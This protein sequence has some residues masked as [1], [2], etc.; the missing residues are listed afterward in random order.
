MKIKFKK[1]FQLSIYLLVFLW[2]LQVYAVNTLEMTPDIGNISKKTT[3]DSK[4]KLLFSK[5]DKTTIIDFSL[6]T[7][8]PPSL[9]YSNYTNIQ[10]NYGVVLDKYFGV[11]KQNLLLP[12][13]SMNE[14][15]PAGVVITF[16][17]T[18]TQL[19]YNALTLAQNTTS[20]GLYFINGTG[21][22]VGGVFTFHPTANYNG[23]Q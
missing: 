7:P 18:V 11:A 15:D 3:T 17:G 1:V 9:I 2:S 16:P 22:F 20:G 6:F 8:K 5:T 14:D 12:A 23:A 21:A 19:E 13:V 10:S 4:S